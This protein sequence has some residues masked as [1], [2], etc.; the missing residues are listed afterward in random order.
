MG[1]AFEDICIQ[2]LKLQAKAKKLPFIPA[3]IGKWWGNNPAIHA[4][5]DV[6]IL[7]YNRKHTEALF[8]ECK[9]TSR[10]MPMEE[11]ED[12]VIATKAFPD[13]L[14][15]HL[16]FISKSGYTEPVKRRAAEEGAVLYTIKDLF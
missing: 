4:Q 1:Q 6:D 16:A 5:D 8:C 12:L 2:F 10:P 15:K 9:F 14:V 11:Y 3:E 13:S 7:A